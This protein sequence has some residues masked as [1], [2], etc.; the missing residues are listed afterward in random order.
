MVGVARPFVRLVVAL[1]LLASAGCIRFDNMRVGDADRIRLT[2]LLRGAETSIR[3]RVISA[4]MT[5]AGR[6]RL[7]LD[8]VSFRKTLHRDAR[9]LVYADRRNPIQTGTQVSLRVTASPWPSARNPGE[10]DYGRFLSRR[11]V[12]AVVRA[13]GDIDVTGL[14]SGLT[15]VTSHLTRYVE[16][17]LNRY[18]VSTGSQSLL[19]ALMLGDRSRIDAALQESFVS[20]GLVHL[21]AVSGLHVMIIGLVFYRLSGSLLLRTR[22]TWSTAELLRTISTLLVLSLY[23]LL[24]GL[25]TSVVRAVTMTAVLLM[26]TLLRRRTHP[27]NSLGVACLFILWVE[28]HSLFEAG[29][30]LSF[31]AVG[32]IILLNPPLIRIAHRLSLCRMAPEAVISGITVSV[33]ATLSTMPVLLIHFGRAS[34]AG[35][36]L[37]VP[38]IPLTAAAL[39]STIL[40]LMSSPFAP[41]AS[42]FGTSADLTVRMLID[43]ARK[44]ES[45]L[46]GLSINS[47]PGPAG[48]VLIFATTT[49]LYLSSRPYLLRRTLVAVA[50]L[51]SLLRLRHV[52]SGFAL[53]A[54]FLDVGQGDATLIK[55]PDGHT[56]LVDAGP[57]TDRF[58]AGRRIVVPYLKRN[59]IDRLDGLVLTH[60]H[61][62][63]IGGAASILRHIPVRQLLLADSSHGSAMLDETIRVADSSGAQIRI[64]RTGDAIDLGRDVRVFVLSPSS[65]LLASGDENDRSIVLRVEYG[66]T[67]VL[68]LGDAEELAEMELVAR[69]RPFLAADIVKVGHHGSSTSSHPFFV[70]NWSGERRESAWAVVS[71]GRW[72]AYGLPSTT[73]LDRWESGGLQPVSTANEGAILLLSDGERFRR[74]QWRSESITDSET[75]EGGSP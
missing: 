46:P 21:L 19:R 12:G 9:I 70:R 20:T 45:M 67:S 51:A 13:V 4:D 30:Q 65:G 43:L 50:L 25:P 18:V 57:R 15:A 59:Q 29:F 6:Q 52:Q 73:V 62:D 26:G 31:T 63:H 16:R 71:V 23:A 5:R 42:G 47:P 58:D 3:G 69:H 54:T 33:A 32:G 72:N 22:L 1:T 53:E 68:L 64:V 55:T 38:A 17:S 27:L 61:A 56:L 39:S 48:Y 40:C 10:F 36:L 35:I 34:L 14:A 24:T 11:G 2:E 66:H 8:D 60:A 49:A 44:G 75:S 37:N 7:L 28:P 41:V 74:R